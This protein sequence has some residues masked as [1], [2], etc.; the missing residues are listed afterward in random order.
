MIYQV[1][2]QADDLDELIYR[3]QE[4]A[5][6]LQRDDDFCDRIRTKGMKSAFFTKYANILTIDEEEDDE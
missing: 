5:I 1:E 2:I 6:A 4:T 3:I